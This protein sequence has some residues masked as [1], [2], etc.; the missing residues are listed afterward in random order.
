MSDHEQTEDDSEALEAAGA[1]TE[2][3]RDKRDRLIALVT[4]LLHR[5]PPEVDRQFVLTALIPVIDAILGLHP[6]S[7]PVAYI[8]PFATE[9]EAY[10]HFD[11]PPLKMPLAVPVVADLYHFP[12][13]SSGDSLAV[14]IH[15]KRTITGV[16]PSNWTATELFT[17]TEFQSDERTKDRVIAAIRD[18]LAGATTGSIAVTLRKH[19]KPVSKCMTL[20]T[21]E[22]L[23]KFKLK[24]DGGL[25]PVL[26]DAIAERNANLASGEAALAE[27]QGDGVLTAAAA[28]LRERISADRRDIAEFV[29]SKC[30]GT[31]RVLDATKELNAAYR[32]L[33]EAKAK[34]RGADNREARE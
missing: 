5:A 27:A 2:G 26:K 29:M 24:F 6:S 18:R 31:L 34:R 32:A 19:N 7:Q 1:A 9:V 17:G 12:I 20:E 16:S 25:H 13:G 23:F 22:S 14:A 21:A 11:C 33:D 3:I 8:G 15:R 4:N 30:K 28:H 10:I